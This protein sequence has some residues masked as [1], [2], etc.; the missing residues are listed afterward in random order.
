LILASFLFASTL[1]HAA[2]IV[3][4]AQSTRNQIVDSEA[5]SRDVLGELY[6]IQKR[7]KDISKQRAKLNTLMLSSD[8]DAQALA[9]SVNIVEKELSAQRLQ[10][11]RRLG[12][13][14]RWNSPNLMPFMFS[15]A[16]AGE[17]ARNLRYMRLLSE[18]DFQYLQTYQNTLKMARQQRSKLNAKITILLSLKK[19]VSVEENKMSDVF[20]Q[21]TNLL[22]RLK[23]KKELGLRTLKALRNNH[24]EL[25]GM[26]RTGFFEKRGHLNPPVSGQVESNYGTFFDRKYA[27]RLLK[28]GWHWRVHNE[29]VKSV[30]DGEVAYAGRLPGYGST[31]VIDH[32]DHYFTV[33]SGLSELNVKVDDTVKESQVVGKVDRALYFEIRHFSEAIDPASWIQTSNS[34]EI[35]SNGGGN[36]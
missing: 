10:L 32:G 36:P 27:F 28:K 21:K 16:S 34:K 33:Y 18:K 31:V 20:A 26:L 35:A 6:V 5:E 14:Y 8:G 4:Q 15:S 23:Q 24:P 7:V 25:E 2:D 29:E 19:Q 12:F 22:A 30:F 17:F 3:S 1:A 9:R 11:A 13:L